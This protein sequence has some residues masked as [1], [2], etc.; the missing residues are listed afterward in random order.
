ML[1]KL[2][3]VPIRTYLMVLAKMRLPTPGPVRRLLEQLGLRSWV[4]RQEPGRRF[5]T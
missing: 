4:D 1:P 2:L 3:D 5:G